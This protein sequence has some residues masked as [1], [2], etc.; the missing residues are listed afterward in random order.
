V[1]ATQEVQLMGLCGQDGAG[2]AYSDVQEQEKRLNVSHILFRAEENT[3]NGGPERR[4][5]I[6]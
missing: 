6:K 4:L 3:L 1:S 2:A 5:Q